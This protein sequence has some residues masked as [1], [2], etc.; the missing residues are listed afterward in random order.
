MNNDQTKVIRDNVKKKGG[1]QNVLIPVSIN[2]Q[3]E[4]KRILG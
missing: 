2:R 4:I 3:N 1:N